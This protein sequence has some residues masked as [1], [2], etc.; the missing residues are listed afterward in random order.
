MPGMRRQGKPKGELGILEQ[1]PNVLPFLFAFAAPS[2]RVDNDKP[3]I[4][5]ERSSF[6]EK[7]LSVFLLKMLDGL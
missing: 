3:L 4:R 1:A 2:N 7:A 6:E 5:H